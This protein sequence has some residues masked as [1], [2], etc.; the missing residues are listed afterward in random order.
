MSWLAG[1]LIQWNDSLQVKA[2][3]AIVITAEYKELQSLRELAARSVARSL[4]SV[5]GSADQLTE[6]RECPNSLIPQIQQFL[7]H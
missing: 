3:K 2:K 6:V 1:S 5:A 7:A 4:E